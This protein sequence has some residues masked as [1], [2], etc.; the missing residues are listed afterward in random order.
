MN[1]VSWQDFNLQEYVE[2]VSL[3]DFGIAFTNQ[4]YWN[5]RLRTTGGRFFPKDFHL[6]FNPKIYEK[7][8]LNV[9]RGIVRH[10]LCHYHLY[11]A[12]KGYR[13]ADRDFKNLLKAVEGLRYTPTYDRPQTPISS[14]HKYICTKCGQGYVRKRRINTR[15]YVCGKCRG[16]LKEI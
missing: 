12:G 5:N 4:A 8:D 13:H 2:K 6:D 3:E 7:F 9:F 16:R 11:K 10:E 14:Q 1:T 15:K